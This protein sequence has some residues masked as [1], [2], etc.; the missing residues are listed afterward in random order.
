MSPDV[1]DAAPQV[2]PG[3]PRGA[4]ARVVAPYLARHLDPAWADAEVSLV[5]GG[6]SNL[7]YLVRGTPGAVVLRRPPLSSVLPTAHD[8]RREHTVM[9]AL[10]PTG[11]PV[12]VTHHLCT[13]TSVLGGVF[14][15]M[16]HVEGH[17]V[18]GAYP[19]GYADAPEQRRAV[20]DALVDV[21][22]VLHAVDPA[23]V[24][25]EGFGRPAGYLE[26]QV[27][28]WGAQWDATR[29]AVPPVPQM[30]ELRADLGRRLPDSPPPA[31]VH[32]DYRLDNTV[33]DPRRPG[34]VAAVLDWEMA[35]LGD[36]LADLGLLLVYWD[37]ADDPPERRAGMPVGSVTTLPG[38][39]SRE[40]VVRRYAAASG[41]DPDRLARALTWY[42]AF[43][44]FKL[45]S[46]VAGIAARAAA[47][48]MVGEGF[49]GMGERVAPLVDLGRT[50]LAGDV[51]A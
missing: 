39:P 5:S 4:P 27:R 11:V 41:Q 25:L 2:P 14:Y 28:R 21:L 40:E 31:V 33:L 50:A 43:G 38:S 26:R 12:P 46:V 34:R 20:A 30:E 29:A 42:V 8:M 35:T 48:A 22:A 49:E 13:D 16:S 1:Q 9:S 6:K 10:A 15:V 7:T 45:A 47:G 17:V 19:P 36:P 51:T 44:F 18:R 24:G 32:G 37:A 3:E 23:A